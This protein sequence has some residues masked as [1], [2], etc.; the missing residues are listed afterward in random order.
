MRTWVQVECRACGQTLQV[1]AWKA[2]GF[3]TCSLE[4]RGR[5]QT[6]KAEM[7]AEERR[8]AG[9]KECAKCGDTLPLSMFGKDSTRIDGLY[10]WCV[11]CAGEA[12]AERYRQHPEP[13]KARARAYRSADRSA[14]ALADK[15]YRQRNADS[16]RRTKRRYYERNREDV[17]ARCRTYAVRHR[18]RYAAYK[19]NYKA[20]KRASV[21]Y[22]SA[23]DVVRLWHRQRGECARCGVRVGKRPS[24][25]GFHVDHVTPLARGGVNWPRNLQLLC[26]PCNTSKRHRTPAEFTLYLRTRE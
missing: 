5:W 20:R 8:R 17:L 9:A 7:R 16:V 19:R 15:R 2:A 13:A 10:P 26:P 1:P 22:H 4:C 6:M 25:G 12:Q 21:G 14:R 23:K 3:K 24:D 18:S 11:G